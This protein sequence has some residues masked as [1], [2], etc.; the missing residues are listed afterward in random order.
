MRR[1]PRLSR[2]VFTRVALLLQHVAITVQFRLR[3]FRRFLSRASHPA[4]LSHRRHRNRRSMKPFSEASIL[5]VGTVRN[6]ENSIASDVGRISAAL[7]SFKKIQWLAVESDS[8]DATVSVLESLKQNQPGFDYFALG[9]LRSEIPKRTERLAFCRNKYAEA[10]GSSDK[11][12]AV[13]FVAV[14]DFDGINSTL[15]AAA[16]ESCWQRDDWDA[17]T[18]NQRGPYYDI[19]TLRH[20]HWCPGDCWQEYRFL[21]KYTANGER[22][23]YASVSSRMITIPT[24]NEWIDVESAFGGFAIYRRNWFDI[25]RYVGVTEDGDE[26]CEH[27]SINLT[28]KKAGAKIFINPQLINA[29]M[30]PHTRH[31]KFPRT[32][33]RGF[34]SIL[35]NGLE[36]ALGV[37]RA[38]EIKRKIKGPRR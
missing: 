5:V 30:T 21:R 22:A 18:A 32:L 16:V 27:V 26:V 20:E 38:T 34:R 31:L 14:A 29:G 36:S 11:Y 3:R 4:T 12:D 9:N 35:D 33:I 7:S 24:S 8:D 28:M 37:D 15:S 6:C 17:C 19:W 10:I 13:D 2:I 23:R 25:V 1:T